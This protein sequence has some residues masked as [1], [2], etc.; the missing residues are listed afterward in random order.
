MIDDKIEHFESENDV[1][2]VEKN[3]QRKE[4]EM[5]IFVGE[6]APDGMKSFCRQRA[7]I[8]QVFQ[9]RIL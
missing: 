9:H 3:N 1:N 7:N 4:S 2:F 6:G 5:Y 8:R